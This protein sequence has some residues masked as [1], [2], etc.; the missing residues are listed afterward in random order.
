[1][2]EMHSF[3]HRPTYTTTNVAYIVDY[4]DRSS[5]TSVIR[6]HYVFL[7]ETLDVK[8]SG[9]VGQLYSDQVLSAVERDDIRAEQSSFR[10]NEMLLTALS[11]KS[12]QQFQLFLD[13]L[14]NCGQRHVR[15]VITD[16][17][18]LSILTY[19]LTVVLTSNTT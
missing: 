14:D 19:V 1:M 6:A 4:D 13:A 10:A 8:F 12:P 15:N 17:P 18:G 16:P 11:R 9:L 3:T 2:H 5:H 7:L